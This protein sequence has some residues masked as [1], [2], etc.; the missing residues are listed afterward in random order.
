MSIVISTETRIQDVE[1]TGEV[2]TARL[3]DGR[4]IS[5]PLSWSWRL[6]DATPEQ[7][8]KFEILGAGQGVRWPG[9]DED[10]SVEGMLAGVPARQMPLPS[11]LAQAR[12]RA[13]RA[14]DGWS[15]FQP[16]MVTLVPKRRLKPP[17]QAEACSTC[18]VVS[19]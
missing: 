5:V 4:I 9:I 14:N 10:I 16:A 19:K 17:L 11:I 2:I 13:E 12:E 8:A 7:R 6:S 15:G 18:E 3:T 1:V